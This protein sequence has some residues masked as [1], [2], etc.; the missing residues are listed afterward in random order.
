MA[1]P[2]QYFNPSTVFVLNDM[3]IDPR[4]LAQEMIVIA[5]KKS[6]PPEKA[7]R[8]DQE[9]S[10]LRIHM[11]SRFIQCKDPRLLPERGRDPRPFPLSMAERVPPFYPIGL[12]I[13]APT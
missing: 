1:N 6:Y 2:F 13:Q 8:R 4:Q 5:D 12:D 10:R 9:R 7:E 11:I 3:P